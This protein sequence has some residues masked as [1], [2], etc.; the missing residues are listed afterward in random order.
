MKV[1]KGVAAASGRQDGFLEAPPGPPRMPGDAPASR[2][3]AAADKVRDAARRSTQLFH[4][5]LPMIASENIV[6]PRVAEMLVTDLHGR[7]AE[8]LP[9]KRYYRS[10]EH[11]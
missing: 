5:G 2:A 1:L 4:D 3:L 10:E 6:S 9:G 7:Y 11:T 8:G